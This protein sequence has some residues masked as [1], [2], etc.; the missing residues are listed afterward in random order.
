MKKIFEQQ[1][2]LALQ[3]YESHEIHIDDKLDKKQKFTI[4]FVASV[5]SKKFEVYDKNSFKKL[6]KQLSELDDENI[7]EVKHTWYGNMDIKVLL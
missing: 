1:H 6:C 2:E 7:I 4:R 5:G 3:T